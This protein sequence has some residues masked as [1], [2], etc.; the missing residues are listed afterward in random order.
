MGFNS[1]HIKMKAVFIL[2][3]LALVLVSGLEQIEEESQLSLADGTIQREARNIDARKKRKRGRKG[4]KTKKS[5]RGKNRAN[6]KKGGRRNNR[7][8]VGRKSKPRQTT[9]C[10]ADV[11]TRIKAYKKAGNEKRMAMRIQA[12]KKNM[13]KKKD[14]AATQFSD[15]A[16]ALDSATGGGASCGSGKPDKDTTDALAKLKNCSK[17]A[18]ELCESSTVNDTGADDCKPKFEAYVA[19]FDACLKTPTC[20]CFA[21]LTPVEGCSFKSANDAAKALKDKCFK[22]DTP[23]SFGDCSKAL[24]ESSGKVGQCGLPNFGGTTKAARNLRNRFAFHKF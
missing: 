21:A 23:G 24:K 17:S 14:K 22:S 16:S 15:A 7:P 2:G 4:K 20:D 6:K 19:A 12:W 13:G 3:A 5:K 1:S 8:K 9:D 11:V 18:A 10:L